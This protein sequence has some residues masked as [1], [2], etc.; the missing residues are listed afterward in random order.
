MKK[1]YIIP[2]VEKLEL[3]SPI[4]DHLFDASELPDDKTLAPERKAPAF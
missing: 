3:E 4:M 1:K 2:V